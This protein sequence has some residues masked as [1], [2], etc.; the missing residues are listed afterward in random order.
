MLTLMGSCKAACFAA[1]SLAFLV[2]GIGGGDG[3]GF[4]FALALS[5]FF[6][7]RSSSGVKGGGERLETE[8][9]KTVPSSGDI[10]RSIFWWRSWLNVSRVVTVELPFGRRIR[11]SLEEV[12]SGEGDLR[13]SRLGGFHED[14]WCF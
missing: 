11:R 14:S 6:L 4:P 1:S 13:E 10:H 5:T 8:A 7:Y 9:E 2:F 12:G 3:I